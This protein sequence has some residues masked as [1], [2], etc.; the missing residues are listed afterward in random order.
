[1]TQNIPSAATTAG[2]LIEQLHDYIDAAHEVLKSGDYV[3]LTDFNEWVQQLCECVM[4]MPL[5]EALLYKDELQSLMESLDDLKSEMENHKGA[6]GEQIGGLQ[7]SKNATKAYQ[8][9][10]HM[11]SEAPEED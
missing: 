6:I 11:G 10:S 7:H 2:L 8:K 3:A 5:E 4:N 9:S 1:M